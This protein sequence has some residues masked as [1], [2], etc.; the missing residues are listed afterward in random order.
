MAPIQV[1]LHGIRKWNEKH[2][3]TQMIIFLVVFLS[4]ATITYLLF[5]AFDFLEGYVIS[6][7][8]I[9]PDS[10]KAVIM[11]IVTIFGAILLFIKLIDD[12]K[13]KKAIEKRKKE[14]LKNDQSKFNLW[15]KESKQKRS[16][17]EFIELFLGLETWEYRLKLVNS[18]SK[19]DLLERNDESVQAV[20]TVIQYLEA[21][22]TMTDLI[23]SLVNLL[24]RIQSQKE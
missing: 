3:S 13:T 15:S 22:G 19:N 5:T 4:F 2:A 20:K 9:A 14:N 17:T 10:I 24:E 8:N 21:K 23:D 18:V 6:I 11:A 1:W 16:G 7:F 12:R